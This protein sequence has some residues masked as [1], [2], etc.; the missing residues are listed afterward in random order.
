M[1]V[2][3]IMLIQNYP[4]ILKDIKI[5]RTGYVRRQFYAWFMQRRLGAINT[6]NFLSNL[7]LLSFLDWMGL[8]ATAFDKASWERLLRVVLLGS[9]KSAAE[10]QWH[11]L[12]PLDGISDIRQRRAGYATRGKLSDSRLNQPLPGLLSLFFLFTRHRQLLVTH[13][14]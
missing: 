4:E 13:K 14:V 9:N 6:K 3:L 7:R 12:R 10:A 11:S 5:N 8:A 1:H 2:W